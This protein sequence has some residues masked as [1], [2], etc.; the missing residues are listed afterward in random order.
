MLLDIK[1]VDGFYLQICR[2]RLSFWE[3]F[4]EISWMYMSSCRVTVF[5]VRVKLWQEK[6]Q[7]SRKILEKNSTITF[8]ADPSSVSRLFFADERTDGRTDIEILQTRLNIGFY[9]IK[10]FQICIRNKLA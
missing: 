9:V 10:Y 8:Y 5:L 7:F 4:K 3:E 2:Q 6:L 1:F